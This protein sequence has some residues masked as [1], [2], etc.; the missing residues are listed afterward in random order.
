V[1][2]PG[3][4][5][6][7]VRTERIRNL[8]TALEFVHAVTIGRE[9]PATEGETVKAV[10]QDRYGD[11]GVLAVRDIEEP[12]PADDEVLIRVRAAPV[13]DRTYPLD[14]AADA[15]RYLELGHPSGKDA[16]TLPGVDPG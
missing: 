10:V 3:P 9:P 15:I 14:Q 13:I 12:V 6:C 4:V 1:P 2:G 16:L 8:D 5:D 7:Q 11:A